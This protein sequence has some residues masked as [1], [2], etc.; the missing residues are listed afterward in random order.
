[1]PA[2]MKDMVIAVVALSVMNGCGPTTTEPAGALAPSPPPTQL[3]PKMRT[4]D[5]THK[6]LMDGK[7]RSGQYWTVAILRFGDTR[8]AE[9]VPFGKERKKDDAGASQVNVTVEAVGQ[10]INAP[11]SGQAPPQMNKRAREILKH[12]LAES[13]AF[14]IVERE[15]ILEILREINF[16]KTKYVDTAS[17]PEEGQLLCVRYLL[18]GS[19]G[20]NEDKTLKDTLDVM[21][22]YR[23]VS[24]EKPG[25]F[26]NIFTPGRTSRRERL[27]ALQKLRKRR[28]Q[29]QAQRKFGIACYL[30][31]YEVRTGR[32]MT[33][34][35]GLGTNDLEAIKDAVEELIEE[36]TDKD[37]GLRVAAVSGETVYLDIGAKGGIKNGDRFQVIHLVKEIR[38]RHGQVIGHEE[39]EV[40]EIE[41][42]E[43]RDLMSIART[44]RKAG[45]IERGDLAKPAKH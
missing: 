14:V 9:D 7:M 13:D 6:V 43:V 1:M 25:F 12:S 42:I 2:M 18:E 31:A 36:L 39:T 22:D 44:V 5:Y 21:E 26:A 16:G 33:S 41:I 4:Y 17:S 35:M 32:V 24:D 34:V 10:Q 11:S 3:P 45:S 19:L 23:D 20:F 37:D 15:R 29:G 8:Q 38:N 30:S 40:G 28:L 27:I